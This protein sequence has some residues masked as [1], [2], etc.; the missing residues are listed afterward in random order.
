MKCYKSV[1]KKVRKDVDL[2][3]RLCIIYNNDKVIGG[4]SVLE[5]ASDEYGT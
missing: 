3:K 2:T 4:K 5:E 1:M